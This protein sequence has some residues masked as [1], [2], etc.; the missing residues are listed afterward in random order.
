MVL[1][2]SNRMV[3]L[4]GGFRESRKSR[5][6][7]EG[8]GARAAANGI[9]DPERTD[10]AGSGRGGPAARNRGSAILC[11]PGNLRSRQGAAPRPACGSAV[12]VRDRRRGAVEIACGVKGGKQLPERPSLPVG[13]ICRRVRPA[14]LNKFCFTEYSDYPIFPS[15]PPHQKGRIMIVASAGRDAVDAEGASDE[16]I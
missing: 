5:R 10:R 4:H 1:F 16:G 2:A 13:L 11:L 6:S 14:I 15:V 12:G 9:A 7:P 3:V 8:G